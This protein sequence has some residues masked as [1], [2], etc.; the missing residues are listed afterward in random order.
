MRKAGA[1]LLLLAV[2]AAATASAT[3]APPPAPAAEGEFCSEA[4]GWEPL[5]EVRPAFG[6]AIPRLRAHRAWAQTTQVHMRLR[7]SRLLLAPQSDPG[8]PE[9]PQEVLNATVARY[10][11][12]RA[13]ASPPWPHCFED[14][15]GL[16]MQGCLQVRA[17]RSLGWAQVTCRQA[18]A[19]CSVQWLANAADWPSCWRP[20]D[21]P[22]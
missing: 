1:A 4:D 12:L 7:P 8:A 22:S 2:C 5:P 3:D 18:R 15:L 21:S 9:V 20:P 10:E 11:D 16:L 19:M 14:E 17:A 13:T 6:G